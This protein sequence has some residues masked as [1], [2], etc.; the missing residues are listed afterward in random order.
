M[1]SDDTSFVYASCQTNSDANY[2]RFGIEG[3]VGGNLILGTQAYDSIVGGVGRLVLGSNNSWTAIL[4][5]SRNVTLYG[6]L[7]TGAPSGGTAAAWKM[8]TLVTTATVFDATR[9]IQL[10]VGGVLYKIAVC[11]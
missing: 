1:R 6:S 3:S 7:T 4:D 11:V 10:D 8:G 2:L 9:Y 5:A